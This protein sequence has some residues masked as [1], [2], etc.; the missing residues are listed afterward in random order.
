IRRITG[1]GGDRPVTRRVHHSGP[2][3][4]GSPPSVPERAPRVQKRLTILKSM[5]ILVTGGAGFIGSN[6]VRWLLANT[7]DAVT[8]YDALTYAGN[9]STLRDVE[10]SEPDRFRFLHENICDHDAKADAVQKNDA[11]LHF[12]AESHIH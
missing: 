10:E 5:R 8:V 4:Y 12:A 9:R 11:E 6:H 7:D 2:V 3:P 1:G